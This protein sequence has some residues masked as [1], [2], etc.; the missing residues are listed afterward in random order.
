[1]YIKVTVLFK[2]IDSS[3]R[4]SLFRNSTYMCIYKNVGLANL[5]GFWNILNLSRLIKMLRLHINFN[6]VTLAYFTRF[7]CNEALLRLVEGIFLHVTYMIK[8]VF[9]VDPH[10][11][12]MRLNFFPSFILT[13]WHVFQIRTF[14]Y[15]FYTYFSDVELVYV[16]R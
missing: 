2:N 9:W 14:N 10:M 4:V 16:H 13:L 7:K 1:M 3:K 8:G 11:C 5:K 15:I 12:L 6:K